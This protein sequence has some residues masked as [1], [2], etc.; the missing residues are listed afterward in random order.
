M[1]FNDVPMA[2]A[3]TS[4][5]GLLQRIF[6]SGAAAAAA[7]NGLG[8]SAP[9]P[10]PPAVPAV[11]AAITAQDGTPLPPVRPPGLGVQPQPQTP[12]STPDVSN[13]ST[14]AGVARQQ[15]G[16]NLLVRLP[17]GQPPGMRD[18]TGTGAMK[19]IELAKGKSKWGAIAAGLAAGM[20]AQEAAQKE[21]GDALAK[22]LQTQFTQSKDMENMRRQGD[23]SDAQAQYYRGLAS[24]GEAATTRGG[25]GGGRTVTPEERAFRYS[26]AERQI[27]QN[28][29]NR[30]LSGDALEAEV[31]RQLAL[32]GFQQGKPL[33]PV[34]G[35]PQSAVGTGQPVNVPP[36][37][38]PGTPPARLNPA[39]AADPLA[40]AREAIARGAD[41]NAVLDRLRQNGIDPSGL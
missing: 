11:P 14:P 37:A 2:T 28:A 24:R 31:T 13:P 16:G 6:G 33:P 3:D 22:F 40:R 41:R 27:R 9:P 20:G 36:G 18:T 35:A 21:Y 5:A 19:A 32:F 12:S 23:L 10:A 34:S 29:Q 30:G 39:P 4:L 1:D 38:P 26:S 17:G 15:P 8:V 7:P 25:G